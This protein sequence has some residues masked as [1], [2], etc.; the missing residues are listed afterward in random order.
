[1]SYTGKTNV[2][3]T[4]KETF[5]LIGQIKNS[6]GFS[7][8]KIVSMAV[9]YFFNNNQEIKTLIELKERT[10][11]NLKSLNEKIKEYE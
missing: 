4:D 5:N 3:G 8:T 2:V 7:K 9:N 1:M 6:T 10:T 11:K